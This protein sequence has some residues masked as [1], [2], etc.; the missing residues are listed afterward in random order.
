[1]VQIF[2]KRFHVSLGGRQYVK[3]LKKALIS[4][5]TVSIQ[6]LIAM[7]DANKAGVSTRLVNLGPPKF[8]QL[9]KTSTRFMTKDR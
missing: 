1:V 4:G 6:I 3:A 8:E 9:S 2:L 7:F 5:D